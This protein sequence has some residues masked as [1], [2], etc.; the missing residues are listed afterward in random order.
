MEKF[1]DLAKNGERAGS[2]LRKSVS[3]TSLDVRFSSASNW[4][5][6]FRLC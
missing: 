4:I 6:V 2:D 1:F 5:N 3:R